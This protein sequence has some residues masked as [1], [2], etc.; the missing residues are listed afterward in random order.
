MAKAQE[1]TSP[2]ISLPPNI[3]PPRPLIFH[4]NAVKTGKGKEAIPIPIDKGKEF[5]KE[6]NKILGEHDLSMI[7]NYH[8]DIRQYQIKIFD[9][10]SNELIRMIPD[11]KIIEMVKYIK[12]WQGMMFDKL[13]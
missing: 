8:K 3:Q 7:I 13:T 5:A 4:Q 2:P 1:V 9:K 10:K 6:A 11:N 12:Q